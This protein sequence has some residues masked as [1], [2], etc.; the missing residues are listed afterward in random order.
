MTIKI[1]AKQRAYFNGE[2]I[3]PGQIIKNFKGDTIPSW[4]K[5]IGSEKNEEPSNP[6]PP[7]A[8]NEN[9]QQTL[10]PPGQ[11]E[12]PENPDKNKNGNDGD[13][14][15]ADS[16]NEIDLSGKTDDELNALLDEL[17][18]KGLDAG[19]YLENTENK[20]VIEQIQELNTEI[21]K[22]IENKGE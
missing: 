14:I 22:K 10:I 16:E 11:N 1:V 6:K 4:A 19:V 21:N 5:K 3:K 15:P 13:Y 20:T 18:T 7:I 9:G 8:E 12:I 2:I 17:I